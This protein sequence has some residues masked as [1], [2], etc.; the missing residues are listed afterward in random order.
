MKKMTPERKD[1]IEHLFVVLVPCALVLL[2]A[3]L[4]KYL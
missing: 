1:N 3:I 4:K 2:G